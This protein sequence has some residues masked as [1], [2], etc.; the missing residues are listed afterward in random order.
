MPKGTVRVKRHPVS[1]RF[2]APICFAG[3]SDGADAKGLS[4]LSR[5]V[6]GEVQAAVEALDGRA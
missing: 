6:T 2:G 5:E 1:I 3:R 4:E